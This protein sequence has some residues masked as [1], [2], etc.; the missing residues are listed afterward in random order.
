MSNSIESELLIANV[1]WQEFAERESV[2]TQ[3]LYNRTYDDYQKVRD[4]I[5]M[6]IDISNLENQIQILFGVD[7]RNGMV[8]GERLNHIELII[9]PLYQRINKKLV[10]A[11]FNTHKKYLPDYWNVIKY[12]IWQP[13][14]I[15]NITLTDTDGG[16]IELIKHD[17]QFVPIIDKDSQKLNILLFI[18]D[19]VAKHLIKKEKY[20]IGENI[21]DIWIPQSIGIY[22]ILESI[23]GE[24]HLL[25]TL[26]KME[27]YL[28]SEEIDVTDRQPIEKMADIINMIA[29][30][31]MSGISICARCN[32]SNKQVILKSCRCKN[33]YYC[34]T[35]CQ[36]AHRQL[37]KLGC[38][39]S[40]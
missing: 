19:S 26:D 34:D 9:T 24:Y 21:R 40:K 38:A 28:E 11:L 32:Y 8:L 5:D 36:R 7:I 14:N 25:N 2:I 39:P 30:N 18:K 10:I 27:I 6:I 31:P 12:K 35:I 37:H 22:S 4:I 29:N 16:S 3:L 20:E 33:V 23:I 15:N 13:N 1:F 17:F